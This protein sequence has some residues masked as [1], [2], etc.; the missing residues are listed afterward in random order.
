MSSIPWLFHGIGRW[1]PKG[2]TSEGSGCSGKLAEEVAC[3]IQQGADAKSF[4]W[5]ERASDSETD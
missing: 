4:M 3:E 5:E 1:A 2:S